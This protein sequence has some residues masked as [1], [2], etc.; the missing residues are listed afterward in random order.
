MASNL[1]GATVIGQH[2]LCLVR[3]ASLDADCS[4]LGGADSGWS[5]LGLI[6][7]SDSVEAADDFVLEPE[8]G[9]GKTLFTYTDPGDIT[10]HNLSGD[11]GYHDWEMMKLL[12][13]GSTVLGKA[14]GPYP[15]KVI[16]WQ[17]PG[18]G[19]NPPAVYFEVITQNISGTSGECVSGVSGFPPYQGHIYGRAKF[20]RGDRTFERDTGLISFTAVATSNPNLATGPWLD[21]PGTGVVGNT[22]YQTVGYSQAQFDTMVALAGAGYG[23]NVPG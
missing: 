15:G 20:R 18:A 10:R 16:G 9:C 3:A 23:P 1:A 19:A 12:F 22:M 5:S 17:E 13:G 14:G 8:N 7:L 21:W 6:T 11:F 4:P 2:S